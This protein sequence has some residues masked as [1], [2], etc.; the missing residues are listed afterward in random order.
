MTV[1]KNKSMLTHLLISI[2][3]IV[4]FL[5]QSNIGYS[6]A[7]ANCYENC[8]LEPG[9]ALLSCGSFEETN[10]GL[11]FQRLDEKVLGIFDT[12]DPAANG[13]V[14]G[15]LWG[16]VSGAG[17][18]A[19]NE[20]NA[21]NLG[22]VFG[23][24]LKPNIATQCQDI[25]LTHYG[26]VPEYL[27][28][29][30][31]VYEGDLANAAGCAGG[32]IFKIDGATGAASLFACLPSH[33]GNFA[34][35]VLD[36]GVTNGT[37]D[38]YT[39]L[40]QITYNKD[41]DVFYVSNF[42]DGIIYT[43]D[44]TGNIV[45]TYD[46]GVA[47][48]DG[49]VANEGAVPAYL[50][51][52]VDGNNNITDDPTEDL[53]Q[54]QRRVIGVGYNKHDD[55]LYFGTMNYVEGAAGGQIFQ[56]PRARNVDQHIFSVAIDPATCLPTASSTVTEVIITT[57]EGSPVS[58]ITFDVNNNMLIA[59][60][61]L[62]IIS[63]KHAHFAD[64]MLFTGGT[65][66]WALQTTYKTSTFLDGGGSGG[67]AD[68]GYN[69]YGSNPDLA[70]GNCPEESVLITVDA[71]L[72]LN[73]PT[74]YYGIA[75]MPFAGGDIASDAYIIDVDG[76]TSVRDKFTNNDVEVIAPSCNL[77]TLNLNC[78]ADG[79]TFTV[80]PDCVQDVLCDYTIT[81]ASGTITNTRTGGVT[82]SPCLAETFAVSTDFTCGAAVDITV[83]INS[84]DG[85]K[86]C[87][88]TE[89]VICDCQCPPVNCISQFGEFSIIKNTP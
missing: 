24:A 37:V 18:A 10:S 9:E 42:E 32:G 84:C 14:L 39:G 45:G 86:L 26:L 82:G 88:L 66:S 47:G 62:T 35:L 85:S 77:T 44:A 53:T 23:L 6:Q 75:I 63:N 89:P 40:G 87:T 21:Q 1:M 38:T 30:D 83:T 54:W 22:E 55:R 19:S 28:Q 52:E 70:A 33:R 49:I 73:A 5:V 34:A 50:A 29:G 31:V 3:G 46:F 59:Q 2:I 16:S 17:T 27:S 76:N 61:N 65:N 15:G 81:S 57:G 78:A 64:A 48:L 79:A 36:N 41:C 7:C 80:S 74:A 8:L 56:V 13:G 12:R 11:T 25:Y 69:N 71:A 51:A 20:W 60:A 43:L 67:G 68:F 4:F 72:G 58:D